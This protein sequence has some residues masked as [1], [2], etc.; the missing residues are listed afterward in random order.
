ML[1]APDCCVDV[2]DDA[3]A[4]CCRLLVQSDGR[5]VRVLV[6]LADGFVDAASRRRCANAKCEVDA[7]MRI[8]L[9]LI[10]G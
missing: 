2:E 9:K 5:A 8:R 1:S 3:R 6:R 4:I 7:S 10:D